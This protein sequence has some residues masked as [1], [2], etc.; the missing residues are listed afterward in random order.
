[1]NIEKIDFASVITTSLL[2]KKNELNRQRSEMQRS[3]LVS[4]DSRESGESQKSYDARMANVRQGEAEALK[5][6]EAE[7]KVTDTLFERLSK[8]QGNKREEFN[9][10]VGNLLAA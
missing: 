3:N 5:K 10:A 1:M 8:L 2:A 7:V 4:D 6:Q 9:R